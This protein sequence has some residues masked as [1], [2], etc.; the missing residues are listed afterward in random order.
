MAKS[1]NHH[2][3]PQFF[4]NG[5]TNPSGQFYIY[6]KQRNVI[7]DKSFYPSTHFFQK[8]R[9][10]IMVNGDSD[11]APE[12]LYGLFENKDK[13]IVKFIQEQI[14]SPHLSTQQLV[15]LQHFL[16]NLF[17]RLP[18]LDKTYKRYMENPGFLG[19]FF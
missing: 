16:S 8:N 7:K 11:D 2:Y 6:D 9:N 3:I 13:L 14:G 5:F 17:F 1:S 18:V 12:Q 15:E 10:T 4:L 19:D